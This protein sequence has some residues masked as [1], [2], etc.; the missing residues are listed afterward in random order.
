MS[1][2]TFILSR[3][4]PLRT[5]LVDEA[6]GQAVYEIDTP[7]KLSRSCATKIRKFDSP[8][9]PPLHRNDGDDDNDSD[10]DDVDKKDASTG[11]EGADPEPME[12]SESSDEMARIYWKWVSSDNRIIFRGKITSRNEFLP[13]AGKLRG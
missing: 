3:N 11:A 13:A 5:T 8:T 7:R 1:G 4:S 6:T 10:E 2:C 12:L 9:Q